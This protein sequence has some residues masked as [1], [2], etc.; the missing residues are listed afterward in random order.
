N[1][2]WKWEGSPLVAACRAGEKWQNDA[3]LY[4]NVGER[5]CSVALRASPLSDDSFTG[6]V[7]VF[8]ETSEA[9]ISDD[10]RRARAARRFP[11]K[12]MFKEMVMFDKH[13]GGNV[14]K[15]LDISQ[16]GFKMFT[17]QPLEEGQKLA[18]CLVLPSQ[19]NGVS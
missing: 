10:E 5:R 15:L 7:V 3:D 6:A 16:G 17:R 11:R 18:L 14:G 19:V 9:D 13:T 12:K 8:R 2:L 1:Q 4:V